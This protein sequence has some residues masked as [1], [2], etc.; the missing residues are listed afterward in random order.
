MCSRK[1]SCLPNILPLLFVFNCLEVLLLVSRELQA[2]LRRYDKLKRRYN[3]SGIGLLAGA[4]TDI[5][6]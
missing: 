1:E 2:Q 5:L 4:Q 6:P 3:R